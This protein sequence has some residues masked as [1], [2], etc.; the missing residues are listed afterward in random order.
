ML[1]SNSAYFYP[2]LEKHTTEAEMKWLD[3]IPKDNPNALMTA[4]VKAPR[5]LSKTIIQEE[6]KDQNLIPNLPGFQVNHWNLVRLSRVWFLSFLVT[7]SKNELIEK[8]ETLFDTAELNELVALF[9]SLSILPYPQVW[10][11]RATDAVR[12][13][14]GF[15]FD[16][17]ALHN[18]F[19]YHE[20]PDIAWNQLVL[21]TIFNEKPIQMIYGLSQRNNQNLAISLISFVKER[22]SA[23]RDVPPEIWQLMV[24]YLS[25]GELYLVETLFKSRR[26]E[27]VI[28]A[29]LIC[30]QSELKSFQL[31]LTKHPKFQ[32]EIQNGKWDWSKL[33]NNH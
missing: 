23:G 3:S 10:L 28:A 13:N 8:I 15:V 17:I 20:F 11:P 1:T 2:L 33:G 19:P 12:S 9:S 7:L 4:F 18:P 22:W 32:E 27:D 26:E 30:S 16:A 6:L 29:S 21:K 5:F 25:E 14:M 24:P 31:L